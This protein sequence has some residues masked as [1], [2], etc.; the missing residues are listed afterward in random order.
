MRNGYIVDSLTSNEIVQ[1]GWKIIKVYEGVIYKENFKL[2][3]FRNV[4]EK[5]LWRRAYWSGAF[6]S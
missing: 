6:S 1:I 5:E 2:K 4:F 3:P